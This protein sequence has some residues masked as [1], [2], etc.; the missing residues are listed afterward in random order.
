VRF[1]EFA[2]LVPAKLPPARRQVARARMID[3][4][5][6]GAERI[7]P[8]LEDSMDAVAGQPGA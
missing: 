1:H 7:G 2:P 4:E 6:L 3:L 8:L 5:Q